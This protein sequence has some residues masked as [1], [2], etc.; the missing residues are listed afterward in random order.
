MT[1]I[2][3]SRL[4]KH[5]FFGTVSWVAACL[6]AP[7]CEATELIY[8]VENDIKDFNISRSLDKNAFALAELV[9]EALF[10][11]RAD[12]SLAPDLAKDIKR[13]GKIWTIKIRTS[14]FSNGK[15]LGC[16]DVRANLE[17]ARNSI[18]SSKSRLRDIE[19]TRC[20]GNALEVRTKAEA[21]HLMG[22]I[23]QIIRIYDLATLSS[24]NPVGSGPYM[25]VGREGKD[26]LLARN[27][28]YGAKT[29][30]DTI[31]F[32]TLRD[33]WLRDLALLS[34]NVDFLMESLSPQRHQAFEKK[35][36][37]KI[38]RHPGQLL[39]YLVLKP[40]KFSLEQRR[41][42]REKLKE[43]KVV[44][45]FWSGQAQIANCIFT[46]THCTSTGV[47]EKLREPMQVEVSVVADE[48][49]LNFLKSMAAALAP[50]NIKLKIRPLEFAT[51]MRRLNE[52]NYDAY[53]HSVDSSQVQNLE[54]L[55]GSRG[56]RLGISDDVLDRAFSEFAVTDAAADE[57]KLKELIDQRVSTE[58]YLL[59]LYR[60]YKDLLA[61]PKITMQQSNA[62]FWRDLLGLAQN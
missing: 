62:G 14:K 24:K 5:I 23:G 10:Y 50:H 27:P 52:K 9:T 19:S 11:Q 12:G 55:L 18:R 29:Y 2:Y 15:V 25:I 56:N 35:S 36:E 8:G 17:E 58:A 37:V 30:F 43:E 34:G 49:Q 57:S 3:S 28:H 40:S 4:L 47:T 20:L 1:S 48:T 32:R 51:Y 61:G 21:P 42:F 45:K 39:F 54:A 44:E 6:F 13:T 22:R 46:D 59:P 60:P 26:I 41:Y 7:L 38:Y 31:R 53:L 16:A 33:V